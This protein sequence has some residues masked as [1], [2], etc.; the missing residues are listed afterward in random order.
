VVKAL[1]IWFM[2]APMMGLV[3]WVGLFW[4]RA[5]VL[6][7]W[8]TT[9]TGFGAWWVSTQGWFIQWLG[10]LP[11]ADALRLL[12]IEGDKSVVYMPWQIL[13]YMVAAAGVGVVVSLLTRRVD[14][15]KLDRFYR[16]SRTPVQPGEDITEPCT[17]PASAPAV[18]R[19]M[20]MTAGGLEIP[21]PS[22]ASVVGFVVSW[23]LVG[24]II[25]GFVW[26]VS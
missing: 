7:A 4:R 3:F 2:I 11:Q 9:L 25:G 13:F 5:T 15:E 14:D 8:A 20:L 21:A 1:E 18:D 6:G 22:S 10:G 16:L 12:W 24:V 17:L 26:I 19:R 23:G